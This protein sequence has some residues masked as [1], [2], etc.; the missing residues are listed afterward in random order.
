MTAAVRKRFL[1]SWLHRHEFPILIRPEGPSA[2][3]EVS[4]FTAKKQVS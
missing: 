4:A 3:L 1:F 2:D